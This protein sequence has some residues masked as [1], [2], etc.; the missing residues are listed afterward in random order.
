MQKIKH[1]FFKERSIY[2]STFPIIE[3]A[4]K[5][6]WEY[7]L[8]PVYTIGILDFVFDTEAKDKT[9]YRTDVKLMDEKTKEVFYDK[10]NY[11]YLE[12]PRFNKKIDEL[13]NNFD[14]WLYVIKNM[15]N[16]NK[17]PSELKERVF[18]KV[19]KIVEI[20]KM[21]KEEYDK[22]EII[23]GQGGLYVRSF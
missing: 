8:N 7:Q 23:Y 2:Y 12:M 9:K 4:K 6:K 1:N 5:G 16:L 11:I 22:Y 13:E 14:K 15:N 3:Q 19:F 18:E 21:T 10:L 17:F 20:G